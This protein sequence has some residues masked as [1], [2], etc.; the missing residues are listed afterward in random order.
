MFGQFKTKAKFSAR[1]VQGERV[2]D[3]M[4]IE[5]K[6]GFRIPRISR[7]EVE[8]EE[9]SRKQ[10]IGRL[11]SAIMNHVNNNAVIAEV[12]SKHLCSP[13]SEESKQMIHS[14]GNV[15]NFKLCEKS[16]N[17]SMSLLS[18]MLDGRNCF[19][20]I[21]VLVEFPQMQY[22]NVTERHGVL[23]ILHFAIKKGGNRGAGHCG[24]EEQ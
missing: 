13:F 17:I 2:A 10:C 24:S 3:E 8:Q 6:I 12:Q 16:L 1:V 21:A 7:A 11:V 14:L 19:L 22:G 15:E 4:T 9:E 5:P 18:E 23:A 20:V